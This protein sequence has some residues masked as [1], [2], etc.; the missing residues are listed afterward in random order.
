VQPVGTGKLAGHAFLSYV[1]EDSG[2]V[3]ELQRVLEA[4]GVRVWRDT[5]NL[6]P[7]EDWH[8]KIRD[9]ITRDALVFIAC[10]SSRSAARQKSYQNEELLLA[11]EQLR[12]R[13]PGDPWLIP[14]RFDECEIPDIELGF[15]RTL[16]SIQRAD[17]FGEG[18]DLALERLR[19]AIT[20]LLGRTTRQ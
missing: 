12:L 10:F 14:V 7:G 6:W 4:A 3:D 9:A 2:E 11:V 20:R 17:L 18:R 8:A 13:R 16:S 15:G 19:E 1:R 5:A